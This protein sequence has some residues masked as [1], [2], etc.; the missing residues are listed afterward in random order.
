MVIKYWGSSVRLLE[1]S[2]KESSDVMHEDQGRIVDQYNWTMQVFWIVGVDEE[3]EGAKII[4]LMPLL[5]SE[6]CKLAEVHRITFSRE[7][8]STPIQC[9]YWDAFLVVQVANL[10]LY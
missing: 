3:S 2:K 7:Y 9:S 4:E 10:A 6:E 1:Y 5:L 8:S